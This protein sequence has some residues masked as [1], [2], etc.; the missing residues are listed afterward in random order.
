M[1]APAIVA[2]RMTRAQR[3]L[4]V[5]LVIS[6]FINYIDRG[7]LSVAAPAIRTEL[8]FD[9]KQLGILLSFFLWPYAFFQ[10]VA[11]WLVDRYSVVWVYGAGFLLWSV[12]TSLTG[13]VSNFGALLA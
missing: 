6:V 9:P 11:G 10:P 2:S 8:N 7:N 4:L 5:L 12:A 1:S 3:G 13:L